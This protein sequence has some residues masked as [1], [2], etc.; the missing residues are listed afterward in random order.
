MRLLLLWSLDLKRL[1]VIQKRMSLSPLTILL[2]FAS[3]RNFDARVGQSGENQT[4][5]SEYRSQDQ[6]HGACGVYSR[7]Q[8]P[9]SGGDG[10]GLILLAEPAHGL[11]KPF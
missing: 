9:Y 11:P 8:R 10:F 3:Y 2:H 5:L 6:R 1:G 7:L 4:D